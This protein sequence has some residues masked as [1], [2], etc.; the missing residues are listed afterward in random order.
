M[1]PRELSLKLIFT[2]TYLIYFRLP[3]FIDT[4]SH[5]QLPGVI[6]S[7]NEFVEEYKEKLA[8]LVFIPQTVQF[9]NMGYEG[10][11][12]FSDDKHIQ[13][14][15]DGAI[16]DFLSALFSSNVTQTFTRED[17]SELFLFEF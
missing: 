5:L 2:I 3:L 13:T 10:L 6:S 11:K 9:L 7:L 16:L 14:I 8:F 17:I 15:V 12:M 1:V 4:G